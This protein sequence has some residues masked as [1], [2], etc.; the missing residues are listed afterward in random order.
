MNEDRAEATLRDVGGTGK[1]I[2]GDLIGD[3][4]LQAEGTADK[5]VARIQEGVG[6]TKEQFESVADT[7]QQL[8]GRAYE[9]GS[10]A[11]QYVAESIKE[12]PL[13]TL[14]VGI[15]IGYAI[16][17]LVHRQ[18]APTPPSYKFWR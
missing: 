15:A 3:A 16:G 17:A 7:A 13:I 10:K 6:R 14:A 2:A 1:K 11:S 5:V 4:K 12:T 18:I 9:A 8:G